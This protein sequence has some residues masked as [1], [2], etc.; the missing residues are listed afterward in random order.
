MFVAILL[1]I[2]L[3]VVSLGAIALNILS[4]PGNWVMLLAAALVSWYSGWN[5][6]SRWAL[7][8]MILILLVGEALELLRACEKIDFRSFLPLFSG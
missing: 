7:T 3:L 4:L 6:P 5:A 2:L 1:Y 8:V